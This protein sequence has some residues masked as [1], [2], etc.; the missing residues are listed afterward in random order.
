MRTRPRHIAATARGTTMMI[1]SDALHL[2][3]LMLPWALIIIATGLM[4]L[5]AIL[6][7]LARNY[8]WSK[9]LLGQSQDLLWSSF[10]LGMLGARLVF[11]LLNAELYFAAPID[12]LK[13]QDKGFHLWGGVLLGALWYVIR[14]RQLQIRFKA[15]LLIIFILFGSGLGSHSNPV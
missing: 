3:P 1:S 4:L 2:G 6:F 5:S 7:G 13:I 11:V 8:S 14:N 10:L 9:Q 12:I 15:T